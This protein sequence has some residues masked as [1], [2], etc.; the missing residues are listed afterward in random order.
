MA[1]KKTRQS[2]IPQETLER[3]RRE[4]AGETY[5]P[6]TRGNQRQTSAQSLTSN[7][8]KTTYEDLKNEYSYVQ[9]DL[10]SMAWL[11]AALFAV[12]IAL[13]FIL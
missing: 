12:L 4:A 11:A 2:N 3:A 7:T 13:S 5:I 6:S 10:R 9:T 8:H 1:R